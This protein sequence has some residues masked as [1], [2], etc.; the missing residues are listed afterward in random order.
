MD[1]SSGSFSLKV[2]AVKQ[3]LNLYNKLPITWQETMQRSTPSMFMLAALVFAFVASAFAVF[4]NDMWLLLVAITAVCSLIS[5]ALFW[6]RHKILNEVLCIEDWNFGQETSENAKKHLASAK[7][8]IHVMCFGFGK[9]ANTLDVSQGSGEQPHL[10]NAFERVLER[11]GKIQILAMDPFS[12]DLPDYTAG[13]SPETRE[14]QA[15]N[16]RKEMIKNLWRLAGISDEFK[17][18]CIE[19]RTY[20][21]ATEAPQTSFRLFMSDSERIFL[22]MY[23]ARYRKEDAKERIN[24]I[25]IK[26]PTGPKDNDKGQYNRSLF[27]GF[28][29]LFEYQWEIARPMQFRTLA[30]DLNTTAL[31]EDE[32]TRVVSALDDYCLAIHKKTFDAFLKSG[33]VIAAAIAGKDSMAA[34]ANKIDSGQCELVV[35]IIVVVPTETGQEHKRLDTLANLRK[36]LKNKDC[37][38]P[39]I[40]LHD[41]GGIWREVNQDFSEYSDTIIPAPCVGCHFYLHLIRSMIAAK[42]GIKRVISGDREKHG[43]KIKLNQ[44]KG[45]LDSL[46][47]KS[48]TKYGIELELPLRGIQDDQEIWR[49]LRNFNLTGENIQDT[50]CLFS[51]KGLIVDND[52]RITHANNYLERVVSAHYDVATKIYGS[53]EQ[54][55]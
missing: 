39:A 45:V 32:I 38:T 16:R 52:A 30:L 53:A 20:A 14:A 2:W 5:S 19:I 51:G 46:I 35:P 50:T 7:K 48:K 26:S 54:S 24:E 34:I 3:L 1:P 17:T 21:Q 9:Y 18:N 10:K 49:I 11:S 23:Q 44:T 4:G 33:K 12:K 37:L 29:R 8:D 28:K 47:S 31:S 27:A 55:A 6:R 42:L 41:D 13:D 43:Q 40:V 36:A 22:S 15:R 25:V